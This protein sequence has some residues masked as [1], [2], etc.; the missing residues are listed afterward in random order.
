MTLIAVHAWSISFWSGRQARSCPQPSSDLA[1]TEQQRNIPTRQT[2]VSH[3]AGS[4]LTQRISTRAA[5]RCDLLRP[6]QKRNQIMRKVRAGCSQTNVGQGKRSVGQIPVDRAEVLQPERVSTASGVAQTGFFHENSSSR[7]RRL[8][9]TGTPQS[10]VK[11]A[12]GWLYPSTR[13]GA[14]FSRERAA[15][16]GQSATGGGPGLRI[17]QAGGG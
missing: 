3:R 7:L 10:A 2:R 16:Q 12:F 15:C 8:A 9:A 14:T 6:W 11:P 5:I 13:M 17:T 1:L 4:K